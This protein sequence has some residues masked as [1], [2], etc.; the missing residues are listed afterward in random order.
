MTKTLI[1]FRHAKSSWPDNVE[2]H[3]R[4]LADRGRKAAPVM[5]KWLAG[6]GLKPTVAL[7]STAKR[8]Q[9]TWALI[10]LLGY[11]AVLHGRFAGWLGN[12][13]TAVGSV[14]CFLGVV[15][16]WYGVNFVLA[17]GLHSYG[18]GGGGAPYVLA[19]AIADMA[20]IGSWS[21]I[22]KKR[23]LLMNA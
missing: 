2:D 17:A 9:E 19:I 22:Y 10:A 20:L 18:F 15:M 21:L 6:K 23:K 3:E 13:G 7:V 16:A 4:S 12:F 1:L 8:T 5:A 14:I 11:L